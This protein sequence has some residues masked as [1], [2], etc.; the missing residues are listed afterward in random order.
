MSFLL[1]MGAAL[2]V[3]IVAA[4]FDDVP[5]TMDPCG[6]F[7]RR[8]APIGLAPR[9]DGGPLPALLRTSRRDP[10][11]GLSAR[12]AENPCSARRKGKKRSEST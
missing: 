12:L 5:P 3:W 4:W 10:R 11:V 9:Y 7:S 2:L 1:L 6:S 8:S